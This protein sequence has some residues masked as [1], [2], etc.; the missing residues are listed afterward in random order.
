MQGSRLDFLKR[1]EARLTAE[2]VGGKGEQQ[3]EEWRGRAEQSRGGE[4]RE[5]EGRIDGGRGGKGG[6]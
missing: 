3:Q 4:G 2:R 6:G 1:K 5:E